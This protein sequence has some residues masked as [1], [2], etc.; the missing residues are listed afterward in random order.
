MRTFDER[1]ATPPTEEPDPTHAY[2]AQMLAVLPP[3]IKVFL[4][5]IADLAESEI[6][7]SLNL[8]FEGVEEDDVQALSG[9]MDAALLMAVYKTLHD[10]SPWRPD[11]PAGH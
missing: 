9:I 3:E 7:R 10:R 5:G 11:S 1:L 2:S 8:A 4:A 6:R